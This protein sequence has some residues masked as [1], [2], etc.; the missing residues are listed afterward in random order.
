MR[1][2]ELY[3][4]DAQLLGIYNPANDRL[5]GR[6]RSDTRKAKLTLRNLNRL[7]QIRKARRLERQKKEPLL[8]LM[9]GDDV[10]KAELENA[11]LERDQMMQDIEMAKLDLERQKLGI[12]KEIEKAELDN[13]QRQHIRSMAMKMARRS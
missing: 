4:T 2:Y 7:N 13:D 10:L 8:K 3:E 5:G 9:Y 6:R 12:Q 1:A 11:A